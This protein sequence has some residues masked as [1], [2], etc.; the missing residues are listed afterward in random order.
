MHFRSQ[1][2][3]LAKICIS[4][5]CEWMYIKLCFFFLFLSVSV[6]FSYNRKWCNVCRLHFKKI[7]FFISGA[8]LACRSF[9]LI[10]QKNRRANDNNR[11]KKNNTIRAKRL[12]FVGLLLLLSTHTP[13]SHTVSS[14]FDLR[15]W[16]LRRRVSNFKPHF[17][18]DFD[19]SPFVLYTC[20]VYG[21]FFLL[22][23]WSYLC[24]EIRN[25]INNFRFSLCIRYIYLGG[26]LTNIMI[27]F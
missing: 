22:L 16:Q 27:I 6:D 26:L 14:L 23:F 15:F 25:T 21:F 2:T 19:F 24:N 8:R 13:H 3:H 4:C 7:F 20:V 12:R 1:I 9:T 18:F 11:K 17:D 10:D 5:A